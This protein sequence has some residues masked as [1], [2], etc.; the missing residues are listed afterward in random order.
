MTLG[1]QTIKFADQVLAGDVA[2]NHPAEALAGVLIDD[3]HDLDRS[4]V[5]GGVKLKVHRPHLIRGIRG[6]H[7]GGG[8]GAQA[9]TA[10]PL[11]HPKALFA[12]HALD[13]LVVH[14]PASAPAS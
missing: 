14:Y 11:R 6:R 7:A 8:A 2:I 9:F 3:G 10:V 4:T 5:G 12:P 13:L 1:G